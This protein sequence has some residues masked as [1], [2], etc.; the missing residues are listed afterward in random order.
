MTAVL[1]LILTE[2]VVAC[3]RPTQD[4]ATQNSSIGGE[5]NLNVPPL[6]E[7]LLAVDSCLMEE[8]SLF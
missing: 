3:T 7:E 4:Q 6:V 1:F 2:A 8:E 5:E